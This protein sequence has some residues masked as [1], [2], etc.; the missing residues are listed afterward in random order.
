M[1][2]FKKAKNAVKRALKNPGKTI[3]VA[4]ASYFGGPIGGMAAQT[5]LTK[6]G[7]GGLF[8]NKPPAKGDGDP[9]DVPLSPFE[10]VSPVTQDAALRAQT[11]SQ[12]VLAGGLATTAGQEGEDSLMAEDEVKKRRAARVL[13]G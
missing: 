5:L 9:E 13:L 6:K 10:G 1:G 8:G 11:E 7:Y 4:A 2:L 12:R 3:A